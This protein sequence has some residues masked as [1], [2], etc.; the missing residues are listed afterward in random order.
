MNAVDLLGRIKTIQASDL[1]LC[2]AKNHDYGADQDALQNLR[3]FGPY[4]IIVRLSDKFARIKNFAK[5]MKFSCADEVVMDT[6]ADI[7]VYASL[8][9]I[10]LE[11]EQTTLTQE[12]YPHITFA[13]ANHF[14]DG[15]RINIQGRNS[16]SITNT[17]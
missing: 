4:G 12:G 7:R 8:L 1:E 6:I 15:M 3:D 5:G 17:P 13:D 14:Q 9:Q 11:E 16:P 2:A 10:M